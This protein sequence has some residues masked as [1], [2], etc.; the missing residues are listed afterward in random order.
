MKVKELADK[1]GKTV[2]EIKELTGLTHH[3]KE[4]DASFVDEVLGE[5]ET[6][7]VATELT[8][9]VVDVPKK[10]ELKLPDGVTAEKVWFSIRAIRNKSSLWEYRSLAEAPSGYKGK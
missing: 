3:N 4:V 9:T 10:K 2:K 1:S 5:T 7:D 6:V 8:K